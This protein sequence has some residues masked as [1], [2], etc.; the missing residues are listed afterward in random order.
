MWMS[1]QRFVAQLSGSLF[2]VSVDEPW[3]GL[4]DQVSPAVYPPGVSAGSK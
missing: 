4:F 2:L 3:E 1:W